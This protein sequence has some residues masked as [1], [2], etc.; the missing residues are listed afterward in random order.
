MEVLFH[1][2]DPKGGLKE[3]GNRIFFTLS[4]PVVIQPGEIKKVPT[5]ATI[6]PP[7]GT[8][9]LVS[10]PE[11]L[12]SRALEIFPA[13]LILDYTTP[14]KVLEIPIRNGGRNQINLKEG[15]VIATAH[16]VLVEDWNLQAFSPKTAEEN[17]ASKTQP[18]RKNSDITF[19]IR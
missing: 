16:L 13:V 7:V 14:E 2:K 18:Q 5:G 10:T 9:I 11:S 3:D 17:R 4:Q 1:N 15:E 8:I 12:Y 19:E 6:K